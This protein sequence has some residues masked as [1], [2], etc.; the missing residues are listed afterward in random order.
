[1]SNDL[2]EIVARAIC[3]H[4]GGDPDAMVSHHFKPVPQWHWHKSEARNFIEIANSLGTHAIVP[5][6]ATEAMLR[7][8]DE[9]PARYRDMWSAMV[10]AALPLPGDRIAG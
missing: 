5:R 6:E 8:A 4:R 2:D 9:A 3:K 1:M 7:A 10:A